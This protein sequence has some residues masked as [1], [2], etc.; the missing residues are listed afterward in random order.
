MSRFIVRCLLSVYLIS[1][2]LN[3]DSVDWPFLRIT[4]V[5]WLH[6]GAFEINDGQSKIMFDEILAHV[7]TKA[8]AKVHEVATA[9]PPQLRL[10]QVQRS[11][12]LETWPRQFNLRPPTDGSIALYFFATNGERYCHSRLALKPCFSIAI[13]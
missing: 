2:V 6:R 1:V 3:V 13:A 4:Y 11:T 10:E 8:V 5:S 12:D 7:S 9:L